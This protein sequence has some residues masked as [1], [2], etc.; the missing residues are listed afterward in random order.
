MTT[1]SAT[2]GGIAYLL[3]L[4]LVSKII[5]FSLNIW[6]AN[7]TSYELLGK[8]LEFELLSGSILFICRENCR[9]ALMRSLSNKSALKS[10]IRASDD[11]WEEDEH[12]LVI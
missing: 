2:V 8:V 9:L 11:D 4:S 6:L 3:S 12:V 7:K 1:L 5:S 10:A